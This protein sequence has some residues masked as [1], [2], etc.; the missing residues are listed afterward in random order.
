MAKRENL[1][2]I[3]EIQKKNQ[4]SLRKHTPHNVAILFN[5]S[6]RSF[7]LILCSKYNF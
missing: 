2:F 1:D 6:S 3:E 4:L 7:G 5:F